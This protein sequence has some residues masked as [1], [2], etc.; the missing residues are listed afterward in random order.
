M[1]FARSFP[2][3]RCATMAFLKRIR[4][5]SRRAPVLLDSVLRMAQVQETTCKAMSCDWRSYT[6]RH[7]YVPAVVLVLLLSFVLFGCAIPVPSDRVNYIG[8]WSAL[9]MHLLITQDGSVRY[10]RL[11]RGLETS[12]SGPL[13]GFEGDNFVVGLPLLSTTFVVSRPPYNENGTWKMVVDGVELTK[14]P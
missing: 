12:I 14:E 11:R 10:W 5:A 1:G 13:R 7:T 2:P 4:I 6:K 9:D 8:E 3:E